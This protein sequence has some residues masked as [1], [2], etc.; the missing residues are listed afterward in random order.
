LKLLVSP[1]NDDESLFA[2]WTLLREK[3]MVVVVF[4][5][6]VQAARGLKITWQQRRAE[7][8]AAC[9]ILGVPVTFLGFRDDQPP[10]AEAIRECLDLYRPDI[11][12]YA[13]AFEE[14]GHP[15]H[16]LVARACDGLTIADRYLTY[17]AAGKSTGGRVV[18][19]LDGSWIALK[20]RALAC[21]ESQLSLDP[22]VACWPHFTRDMT[23]YYA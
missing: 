13:P 3:P 16:N 11:P 22:R 2:C 18:P 19:I 15:Q 14:D 17:T 5:G 8:L 4:D 20:H 21:Y 23:E 1:H 12:V 9:D 10:T 6:Y 7:T